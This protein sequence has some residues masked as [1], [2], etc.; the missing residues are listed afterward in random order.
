[1]WLHVSWP[2]I[3][4]CVTCHGIHIHVHDQSLK[5]P[6][7][8][9]SEQ[10]AQ[11]CLKT[12]QSLDS[13][14]KKWKGHVDTICVVHASDFWRLTWWFGNSDGVRRRLTIVSPR[15]FVLLSGPIRKAMRR[16]GDGSVVKSE[17]LWRTQVQFPAAMA[18]SSPPQ[19]QLQR[20]QCL[21]PR[22]APHSCVNTHIQTHT[23]TYT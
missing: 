10:L 6:K 7:V 17:A 1:M 9:N 5:K 16:L 21:W 3:I 15:A 22:W 18:G 4:W 13:S 14:S 20:I 23:H 19:L 12:Q 8:F 11:A 2:T